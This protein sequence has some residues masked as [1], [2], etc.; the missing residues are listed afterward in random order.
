[1]HTLDIDPNADPGAAPRPRRGQI[2]LAHIAF[3]VASYDALRDAYRH[4]LDH[5]VAILRATNHVN[6][7]SLYF[8]DPDGNTLEIYYEVPRALDL[9]PQGRED[10]NEALPVTRPG[11]PLPA[12]IAED[13]PP[14]ALKARLA[15]LETRPR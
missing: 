3:Q 14:P 8:Q 11:E 13:W 2:G 9:F 10:L 6:Q 5:G 15:V 1:Y 4:L 12:W 7:R